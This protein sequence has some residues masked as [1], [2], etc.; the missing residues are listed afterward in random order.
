[1]IWLSRITF[2]SLLELTKLLLQASKPSLPSFWTPSLTPDVA[3]DSKL[4][5][6]SKKT[7]QVASCPAS[8]DE[9]NHPLSMQHLI[10]IQFNEE[11]ESSS[12]DKR[13]T[14]PSCRKMLSNASSPAMAMKCGH[15][16]CMNCIKQFM[17]PSKQTPADSEIPIACFVCDVPLALS[18]DKGGPKSSLPSGMIPL[19]SEG[20]GFS[21][22]G[23]STVAKTNVAFQC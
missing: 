21:A 10:T 4:L 9:N 5:P 15:V 19:K 3:H 6:S 17:M 14:C 2:Y 23:A 7:K 22:R 16:L 13:R 11:S 12:K 20:T 18:S 1:M 8:S